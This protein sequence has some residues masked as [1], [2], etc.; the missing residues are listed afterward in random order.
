[1]IHTADHPPAHV[2]CYRQGRLVKVG[3][4]TMNVISS[5]HANDRDIEEAVLVVWEHRELLLRSWSQLH[6]QTN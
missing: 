2:H 3:L 5:R 6:G 1:M 4:D